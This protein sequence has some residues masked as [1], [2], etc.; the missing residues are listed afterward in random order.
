MIKDCPGFIV[1]IRAMEI[2]H[3]RN[4]AT[5]PCN[6][7][8]EIESIKVLEELTVRLGC[9][10][11]HWD[12]PSTT[13]ACTLEELKKYRDVLDNRLYSAHQKKLN[14][15]CRCKLTFRS[16]SIICLQ[17]D[18]CIDMV[19]GMEFGKSYDYLRNICKSLQ[20]CICKR[21]ES[22]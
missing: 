1:Y 20:Y 14:M 22:I 11:Q 7:D 3:K 18:G 21:L 17:P 8:G 6:N 16:S 12:F 9:T 2:V 13:S 15:P 10:P 5:D 4:K 19:I